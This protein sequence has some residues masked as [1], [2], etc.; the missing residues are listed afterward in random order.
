MTDSQDSL[1]QQPGDETSKRRR[2][3]PGWVRRTLPWIKPHWKTAAAAFGSSALGM[4]A[5]AYTPLVLRSAIDEGI[6][7]KSKSLTPYLVVLLVIA[8]IRFATAFVRRWLGGKFSLDF[9]YDMRNEIYDHLQRLDF[10][11]HDELETGQIVSRANTDLRILQFLYQWLPLVLGSFLM[12]AVA[13]V[14]MLSVSWELALVS[15]VALP[16]VMW[17]ALRLRTW[18]FA[19]SYDNQEKLGVVA[20]AVD[21][22]VAGV[23]VVKGFGQ[24]YREIMRLDQAAQDVFGSRMRTVRI[25]ARYLAA[26]QSIPAFGAVGVL[27]YAGWRISTGAM[28][29]GTL[30]A[31]TAWLVMILAPVRM[32]VMLIALGQRARAGAERIFELL[33]STPEVN[34]KVGAAELEVN[35]GEIT[36]EHVSFGYLRSEPVLDDFTLTIKAGETV[37]FVGASGSGKSTIAALLPRFYDIQSGSIRIDG[38]D[39]RDVTLESLRRQIGIVFEDTFLFSMTIG[40]NIAFGH[41]DATTEQIEAVA[42]T[43]GIHDF[44]ASLPDGYDAMV[45]EKGLTL[46]GGQRQRIAIARAL[47]RNPKILILDDATS[48]V[49]ISTEEAIHRSL[50]EVL[51]GR[52]TIII[53]HRKS[54]V[55]LA[56]KVVLVEDGRVC[57]TG[58]SDE[59]L[60]SS[61]SYRRLMD[62]N[63]GTTEEDQGAGGFAAVL[64]NPQEAKEML[65]R[66]VRTVASAGEGSGGSMGAMGSAASGGG[67][68]GM[69]EGRP[70]AQVGIG[71]VGQIV[72]G[73]NMTPELRAKIDALP[74]ATDTPNA[75]R[76]TAIQRPERMSFRAVIAPFRFPLA[77][78]MLLVAAD[79]LLTLAGPRL[80]GSGA[81]AASSGDPS[82]LWRVVSIYL[83]VV[84]VDWWVM[85]AQTRWVGRTG[86]NLLYAMRLRVF[87]HLQRLG[88]DF[89]DKEM[90]GRIMTRMT[91]DIDALAS[92]LQEGLINLIINVFTL[93]GVAALLF[94]MNWRLALVTMTVVPPLIGVAIWFRR[95][96][97]KAYERIREK[98]AEVL[99][100]LQESISGV[101]VS[102]AFTREGINQADFRRIAGEHLDARLDGNRISAI[103]FPFVEFLGVIG[104]ALVL[105]A[106]A[107]FYAN[108]TL[109]SGDLLAFILLLTSFFAPIQQLSQIFDT[110]QQAKAA[111]AKL[112]ELIETDSSTPEDPE[113]SE[114]GEIE[115]VKLND[116]H[117]SYGGGEV[118]KGVDLEIAPGETVAL[119]GPTGAGKS[120]IMKLLAR[121]YDP[122]SGSITLDGCDLKDLSISS[123]RS[124]LG[125][126]PQDGYLFTG[127]IA[128]NIAYARPD[129]SDAEIAAAA[130]AVGADRFIESLPDG[131]ET[132]VTQEGRSLSAGER[133]LIA[134]ARA[135]LADPDLL[136]LDEATSN[137]DLET[138]ARVQKA[139]GLLASGRTTLLIAHRL[140]TARRST[141]IAVLEAGRIAEFGTHDEL[142][143]RGGI[144]ADMWEQWL[145]GPGA[146]ADM[147]SHSTPSEPLRRPPT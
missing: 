10:A 96:S 49:D 71:G 134:L 40:E 11:R 131:Y 23:Q 36:L 19:A 16:P 118:L 127:T 17:L 137:L 125:L 116:I 27:A 122:K 78:G 5:T 51:S 107:H 30:L 117:F 124:R 44:I 81:D 108:G 42:Q 85:W 104:T 82:R 139:M 95:A 4:A 94:L 88:L 3:P 70:G 63:L 146:S 33:D 87:A 135:W 62:E 57:A 56:D 90:S 133:Q 129:A 106:G 68:A 143:A 97:D 84:F 69:R 77:I 99:A 140:P 136:L 102:Q 26:I 66:V 54:T 101:R 100:H 130:R 25:Q 60:E 110:Y 37:A 79:A 64:A 31:F 6:V 50:K 132:F 45:G 48:S 38:H 18:I 123:Y 128:Y 13:L 35:S 73:L 141:R 2:R 28:S 114:V 76:E 24:E 138:E 80:V 7:G 83:A 72:A 93:V 92:L 52:T 8:V 9:E 74:P 112:T 41:P 43:A 145:R 109:S 32:I 75:D 98:I 105:G 91:S 34:E 20:N 89:Y 147:L 15:L 61:E 111:M 1:E 103:F 86:E 47:L 53:A 120:T 58:T 29:V 39:I 46:S 55:V 113:A 59:L 14:L 121:F 126:V 119:V 67:G 12:F 65:G 142:V 21:E 22:T 144:W 115:G